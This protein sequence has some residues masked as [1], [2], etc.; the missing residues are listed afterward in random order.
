M[1][2][3]SGRRLAKLEQRITGGDGYEEANAVCLAG[4]RMK[5][6][7]ATAAELALAAVDKA[8]LAHPTDPAA[9]RLRREVLDAMGR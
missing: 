3:T 4:I 1:T 5:T 6:G 9:E 2:S 7:T 8:L